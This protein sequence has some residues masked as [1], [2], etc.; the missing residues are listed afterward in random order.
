MRVQWCGSQ[1]PLW[2]KCRVSNYIEM[3]Q[4]PHWCR[5]EVSSRFTR[6]LQVTVLHLLVLQQ[7]Q[8]S[9]SGVKADVDLQTRVAGAPPTLRPTAV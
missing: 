6:Y 9:A 4:L 5:Q 7:Q 8:H 2:G 3:T 1:K